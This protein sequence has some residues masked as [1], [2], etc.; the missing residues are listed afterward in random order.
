MKQIPGIA[1][2]SLYEEIT[3]DME[4]RRT[5]LLSHNLGE[6]DYWSITLIPETRIYLLNIKHFLFNIGKFIGIL[7]NLLHTRKTESYSLWGKKKKLHWVSMH[8]EILISFS[9]TKQNKTKQKKKKNNQRKPPT[10][11]GWFFWTSTS[12]SKTQSKRRTV[13]FYDYSFWQEISEIL[14]YV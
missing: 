11:F 10:Y 9:E 8:F 6:F 13:R 1:C 3:L 12:D 4:K 5:D 14:M 7:L 2:N